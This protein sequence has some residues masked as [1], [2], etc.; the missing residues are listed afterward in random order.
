MSLVRVK[1]SSEL[2]R[3]FRRWAFD[4]STTMQSALVGAAESM[5]NGKDH[6]RE[7]VEVDTR[8]RAPGERALRA[9]EADAPKPVQVSNPAP[10]TIPLSQKVMSAY[11]SA[12]V[13]EDVKMAKCKRCYE[14]FPV[15]DMVTEP[16]TGKLF[17]SDCVELMKVGQA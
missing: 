8:G 3:K 11:V 10:P 1:M 17:C 13:D 7:V 12:P 9:V 14:S 2:H 16:K 5:C 4:N 6:K 15:A